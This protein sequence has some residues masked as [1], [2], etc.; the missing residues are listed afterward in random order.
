MNFD[1]SSL[2]FIFDMIGI[3]AC[4]ISG[5]ILAQHKRFDVFGC[6][7]I[8]MVTALGGGTVRDLVLDRNPMFWMVNMEYLTVIT[9]TSVVFQIFFHPQSRHVDALLKLFDTI[10]LAAFTLIGIK[11]ALSMGT[12][13][14]VAM[15]LGVITIVVGGIIRD[16]ICKE[17][18]LVLQHEIYITAALIGGCFY[19]ILQA[20]GIANW[21]ADIATMVIIFSVRMSAIH[22]NWRFPDIGLNHNN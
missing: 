22:N 18:P 20:L 12:N 7:L 10:G 4:S 8:S 3:V 1:S 5:T 14:P 11:V 19:F 17:I 2:I 15:L 6:I 13:I 16:M 9:I 21:V